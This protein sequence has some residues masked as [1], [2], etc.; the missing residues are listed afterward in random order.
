M[1]KPS[2]RQPASSDHL[3]LGVLEPATGLSDQESPGSIPE[4]YKRFTSV[5]AAAPP[6]YCLSPM[7]TLHWR[8]SLPFAS[9]EPYP[10][11]D[12]ACDRAGQSKNHNHPPCDILLVGVGSRD[13]E[14]QEKQ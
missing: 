5:H 9:T 7:Q 6:G 3:Q 8:I 1:Q 2:G 10:R 11:N 12:K 13:P 14:G 4:A